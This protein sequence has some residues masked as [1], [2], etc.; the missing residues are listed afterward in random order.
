MNT[1]VLKI[2]KFRTVYSCFF[3]LMFLIACT[4]SNGE[5]LNHQSSSDDEPI[6]SSGW[7]ITPPDLSLLDQSEDSLLLQES[8]KYHITP[9]SLSGAG[10]GFSK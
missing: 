7:V 2:G 6:K 10:N 3:I 4:Q 5:L 8:S 9:D 1:M